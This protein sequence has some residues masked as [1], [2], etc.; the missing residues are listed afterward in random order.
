MASG[1]RGEQVCGSAWLGGVQ[2]KS[3][4]DVRTKQGGLILGRES[5]SNLSEV[6]HQWRQ[7][8]RRPTR[9]QTTGHRRSILDR[10]RTNGRRPTACELPP[11]RRTI[12]DIDAGDR[13]VRTLCRTHAGTDSIGTTVKGS[14]KRMDRVC[15]GPQGSTQER[16]SS[17]RAAARRARARPAYWLA[18]VVS[19]A[20]TLRDAAEMSQ[21][22]KATCFRDARPPALQA[23]LRLYPPG[24][25][26][27]FPRRYPLGCLPRFV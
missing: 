18:C 24:R 16:G 20:H 13:P 2:G 17:E 1:V 3:S 11:T 26:A 21:Y 14:I 19:A 8:Y 9:R 25:T 7:R 27:S 6:V 15:S 10:R 4:G 23:A 22:Y 12:G 5:V